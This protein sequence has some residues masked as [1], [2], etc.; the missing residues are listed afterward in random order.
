MSW[1]VLPLTMVG[2][3]GLP[4]PAVGGPVLAHI[5]AARPLVVQIWECAMSTGVES[6]IYQAIGGDPALVA[7]V[8]DFYSRVLADPDLNGFFAGV[9]MA[10]LK[11]KQV[12]FFAAALG[13]PEP[14]TGASMREVH[15]GRGIYQMHFDLVAGHLVAA[16][17][18][19]GVPQETIGQIVGA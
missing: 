5:P 19:A 8:D 12:E 7:V 17:S 15:R 10:R 1:P 13:G 9:N 2:N 11:G 6:T 3:A 14:Y 4:G 18:D 16:L